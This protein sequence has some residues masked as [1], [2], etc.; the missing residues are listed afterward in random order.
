MLTS[1]HLY[2]TWRLLPGTHTRRWW[3]LGA[4][5]PDAPAVAMGTALL[6]R[7]GSRRHLVDR[8][9]AGP[10]RRGIHRAGHSL[11]I[12]SALA[13]LGSRPRAFALGVL[14]HQLVDYGTHVDD[15]WP[16]LWPA[17]AR[18]WRA[19][20]SYWQSEHH[21]RGFAAIESASLL[22]ALATDRSIARRAVGIAAL[23][24]ALGPLLRSRNYASLI[25]GS[26]DWTRY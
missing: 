8:V 1:S 6:A 4:L 26:I 7:G 23:A 16:P 13:A 22:V 2:W 18:R 11:L 9:Y 21:A 14:G 17:T 24:L 15:A 3:T 5:A 25:G 12:T 19:P 10:R 20:V